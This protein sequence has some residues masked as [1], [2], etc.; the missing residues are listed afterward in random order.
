LGFR[1]EDEENGR[2]VKRDELLKVLSTGERKALYIL[3]ILFEIEARKDLRV[4]TLIIVDDIA[5]SFDYKNKYAIIEY[6]KD[7]SEL[8][9]FYQILL[10]HNF[11]FFRTVESRYISY[12]HCL[13]VNKTNEKIEFV[14]AEYIK[15]P[16]GHFFA[17]TENN[18]KLL[19][20]IPFVRNIIEYTK[21]ETDSD[22]TLLTSTLHINNDTNRITVGDIKDII[23]R[24]FSKNISVTDEK[25]IVAELFIE[26]ANK[27]LNTNETL[28]LENKIVLSVAIR[29]KAESFMIN[30]I[31]DSAFLQSIKRKQTA[32]ISKR[33]IADNPTKKAEVEVI[34]KVNLITPQNI[35]INSF[36]Y[37]PILDMSDIELKTLYT[38][39]L[40][41][42]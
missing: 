30:E 40:A 5:D 16:F 37:E 9:G 19:A 26:T 23:N 42:K 22:F 33:Y 17:N 27:L 39:V 8:D 20:L 4:E 41:L 24:N 12:K 28:N 1:F 3:N 2:A 14:A 29:L 31:G 35:H 21:G 15:N 38:D 7:I 11:D 10:T 25:S 13:M 34:K 18:I 36:M 32:K 6:L